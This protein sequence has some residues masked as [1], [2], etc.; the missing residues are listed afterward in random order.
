[1]TEKNMVLSWDCDDVF[2]DTVPK[3]V[4]HYNLTYNANVNE[5]NYYGSMEHWDIDDFDVV[6]QRIQG[7]LREHGHEEL[8]VPYPDAIWGMNKLVQLGFKRHYIVSAR[9]DFMIPVTE[10]MADAFFPGCFEEI[11]HTNGYGDNPQTKGEICAAIGAD[12]HTDDHIENCY[13]VLDHGIKNTLLVNR[14]WNKNEAL[15]PGITRV[16]NWKKIVKEII[17]IDQNG[18]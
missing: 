3:I 9:S 5:A 16:K 10:A 13:S 17:R 7:Y 18:F 1:M 6:N 2:V 12:V 11:I 8:V 14:S 4:K 15:R